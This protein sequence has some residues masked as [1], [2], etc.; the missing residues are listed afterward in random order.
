VKCAK[1][2]SLP[3]ARVGLIREPRHARG[4]IEGRSG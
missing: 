2:F 1:R 3:A 4:R